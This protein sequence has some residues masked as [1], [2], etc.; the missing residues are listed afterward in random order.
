MNHS[1]DYMTALAIVF[2]VVFLVLF[3][4]EGRKDRG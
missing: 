1:S 4:W 2:G 3:W